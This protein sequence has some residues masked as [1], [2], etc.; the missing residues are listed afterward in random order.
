MLDYTRRFSSKICSAAPIARR[1]ASR[2]RAS[3]ALAT[4]NE[5]SA[6]RSLM[7]TFASVFFSTGR[8]ARCRSL[9]TGAISAALST[10]CGSTTRTKTALFIRWLRGIWS[11]RSGG[12]TKIV[13]TGKVE[14]IDEKPVE[15]VALAERRFSPARPPALRDLQAARMPSCKLGQ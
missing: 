11:R 14:K 10:R 1:T 12:R 9:S 5:N 7:S 4:T 6:R 3:S 8:D 13:P 15:L 2:I